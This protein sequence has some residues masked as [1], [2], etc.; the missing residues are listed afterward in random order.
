E[1]IRFAVTN[2]GDTAQNVVLSYALPVSVVEDIEVDLNTTPR[3][4]RADV[5]GEPGVAEWD[6][7]LAPGVSE[8]VDMDITITWPDGQVIDWQP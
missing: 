2:V 8:T 3:P 5:N 1:K 4:T 7:A 6:F